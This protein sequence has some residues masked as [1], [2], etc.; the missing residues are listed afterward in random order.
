MRNQTDF[1]LIKQRHHNSNLSAKTYPGAD[2]GSDHHPVHSQI[3]V[4]GS[5][6]YRS[7]MK[8]YPT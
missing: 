2:I 7:K 1:V 5:E 8:E 3:D 6:R 4:K